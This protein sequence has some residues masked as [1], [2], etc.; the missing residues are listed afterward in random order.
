MALGQPFHVCAAQA[1]PTATVK[2]FAAALYCFLVGINTQLDEVA[3]CRNAQQTYT[4]LKKIRNMRLTFDGDHGVRLAAGSTEVVFK[5]LNLRLQSEVLPKLLLLT[6]NDRYDA[7]ANILRTTIV[8]IGK[9]LFTKFDDADYAHDIFAAN[10]SAEQRAV[11]NYNALLTTIDG[12]L[13]PLIAQRAPQPQA[14]QPAIKP[15]VVPQ[16]PKAPVIQPVPQKVQTK[17]VITTQKPVQQPV[18]PKPVTPK[19]EQ[20]KKVTTVNP[21]VAPAQ[22]QQPEKPKAVT[23]KPT[24]QKA[25]IQALQKALSELTECLKTHDKKPAGKV[26]DTK[27]TAPAAVKPVVKQALPTPSKAPVLQ[28]RKQQEQEPIASQAPVLATPVVFEQKSGVAETSPIKKQPIIPAVSQPQSS[29]DDAQALALTIETLDREKPAEQTPVDPKDIETFALLERAAK[30]VAAE[31]LDEANYAKNPEHVQRKALEDILT[32]YNEK[33]PAS[34]V[35]PKD[36]IAPI[37]ELLVPQATDNDFCAQLCLALTP[38]RYIEQS[39]NTQINDLNKALAHNFSEIISANGRKALQQELS[40]L[41]FDPK[42]YAIESMLYTTALQ[43]KNPEASLNTLSEMFEY[44][45]REEWKELI[46]KL[47]YPCEMMLSL[48]QPPATVTINHLGDYIQWYLKDFAPN[49]PWR[50][51]VKPQLNFLCELL[52]AEGCEKAAQMSINYAERYIEPSFIE[53]IGAL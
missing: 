31:K 3:K 49:Q 5:K 1:A 2:N 40:S 51:T 41:E 11:T 7:L 45:P 43:S 52:Y 14:P 16:Q 50:K 23:P 36:P 37:K 30:R 53:E 25:D 17:P 24:Q 4:E 13:A 19:I 20:P 6:P 39:I 42:K 15:V 32:S 44:A 35:V 34:A 21:T 48:P 46:E 9:Q 47:K 26:P 33:H 38:K 8:K 28:P 22:K 12:A 29:G 10:R 27:P 18:A